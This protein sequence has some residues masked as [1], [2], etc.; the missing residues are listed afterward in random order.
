MKSLLQ[1]S[2]MSESDARTVSAWTYLPP[3]HIYNWPSWEE[4]CKKELEFADHTIRSEQYC[5]IYHDQELI[6]YIQLFPMA[7][8][9]RL[10]IFLSPQHCNQGLGQEAVALA[11]K[12]AHIRNSE[13]EIDLEVECWNSRAITCYRR[14]GFTIT[15]HYQYM[16]RGINKDVYCMVYN[17]LLS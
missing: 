8:V 5:S 3:Y 12:E 2:V 10:A 15:D 16:H 1:L 6:G 14:A 4:M 11:V 13:A 9:I 17:R 7:H